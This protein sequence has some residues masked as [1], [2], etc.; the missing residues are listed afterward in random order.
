MPIVSVGRDKLFQ[1][2]GRHYSEKHPPE[3]SPSEILVPSSFHTDYALKFRAGSIRILMGGHAALINMFCAAEE[4]FQALCFDYG[5]ELDDV[6][7][8]SSAILCSVWSCM[9]AG[10]HA[11]AS[12]RDVDFLCRAVAQTSEK[13]MLQKEQKG[14]GVDKDAS[15]EVLYKIDIPAN[16]YDM[17]CLEGIARALNIFNQRLSRV[18][19][20]LAN[21]Q[22]AH[23]YTSF[24]APAVL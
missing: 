19:Y 17:L 6:V 2:L 10:G 7:S 1:S 13:E 8:C 3:P 21:M 11:T 15:E 23:P 16:R 4:E 20:R 5:I 22:G 14:K 24:H 12:G 18:E 9:L